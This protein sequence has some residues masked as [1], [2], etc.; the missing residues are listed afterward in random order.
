MNTGDQNIAHLNRIVGMLL[1]IIIV[2]VAYILGIVEH[3]APSISTVF[4]LVMGG[5]L[6]CLAVAF[7]LVKIFGKWLPDDG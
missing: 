2:P 5:Y 7:V 3:D 4:A 6:G 1:A